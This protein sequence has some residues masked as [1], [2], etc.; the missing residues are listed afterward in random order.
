[1]YSH[2]RFFIGRKEFGGDAF[3]YQIIISLRKRHR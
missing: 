3:S 1:M 2:P